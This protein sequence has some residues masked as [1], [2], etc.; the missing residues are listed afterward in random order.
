MPFEARLEEAGQGIR[1]SAYD[2]LPSI[3]KQAT[4]LY[5]QGLSV[6]QV[7]GVLHISKTEAGRLRLRATDQGLLAS[8][9]GDKPVIIG[10]S[11]TLPAQVP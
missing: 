8:A 11:I 1:W 4:E 7:A 6:R 5:E 9:V 2:R 10:H 3:L